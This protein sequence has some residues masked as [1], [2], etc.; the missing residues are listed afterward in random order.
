LGTLLIWNYFLLNLWYG[1]WFTWFMIYLLIYSQ[2]MPGEYGEI[3]IWIVG[4]VS[5]FSLLWSITRKFCHVVRVVGL[6]FIDFERFG[7][8]LLFNPR[9]PSHFWGHFLC[10]ELILFAQA[11]F[12]FFCIYIYIYI[13]IKFMWAFRYMGWY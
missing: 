2:D 8:C 6:C 3:M 5:C 11:F 1:F 12:F 7:S 9:I 10:C 13:W 4:K